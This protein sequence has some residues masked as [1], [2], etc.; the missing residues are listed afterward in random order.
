M[1]GS[2]R[3][4]VHWAESTEITK[5]R[6]SK[7]NSVTVGAGLIKYL[8]YYMH[9]NMQ[10]NLR[11]VDVPITRSMETMASTYSKNLGLVYYSEPTKAVEVGVTVD[12]RISSFVPVYRASVKGKPGQSAADLDTF[13]T[14]LGLDP[15]FVD[16]TN[17]DID[18]S[19]DEE[20]EGGGKRTPLTTFDRLLE[21]FPEYTGKIKKCHEALLYY[22]RT[23]LDDPGAIAAMA[24]AMVGDGYTEYEGSRDK[25]E[26]Q[27]F[28][29]DVIRSRLLTDEVPP[30]KNYGDRYLFESNFVLAS[31][32]VQAMFV[33][34]ANFA[35]Y[36]GICYWN[37]AI[38]NHRDIEKAHFKGMYQKTS[39][40]RFQLSRA[41]YSVS[42]YAVYDDPLSARGD[43]GLVD[44]SHVADS[45]HREGG[46]LKKPPVVVAIESYM[47]LLQDFFELIAGKD[48]Y[49]LYPAENEDIDNTD[50]RSTSRRIIVRIVHHLHVRF[51]G[52][53][54]RSSL[55]EYF[56]LLVNFKD[57]Y[58]NDGVAGGDG[59]PGKKVTLE[60]CASSYF[61]GVDSTYQEL[62]HAV[63]CLQ[64]SL[65]PFR[66]CVVDGNHRVTTILVLMYSTPGFTLHRPTK[67]NLFQM[68]SPC[69]LKFYFTNYDST[70]MFHLPAK[71]RSIRVYPIC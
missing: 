19:E 52:F 8:A 41:S 45:F 40:G 65:F 27:K 25:T 57:G 67:I 54:N 60:S 51:N 38:V 33:N 10:N 36:K 16:V 53:A 30:V 70:G 6:K 15:L 35:D 47:P 63:S 62:F 21:H 44:P 9:T 43:E 13:L 20:I 71:V 59:K 34:K 64:Q 18:L 50:A 5:W 68:A 32:M 4:A 55:I 26:E 24:P 66:L 58:P 23:Y 17:D 42:A 28:E 39:S 22:Y 11:L 14:G 56:N 7:T 48:Y 12:A 1:P 46:G 29:K 61:V 31:P 37:Q 49:E 69:N 2:L 3:K